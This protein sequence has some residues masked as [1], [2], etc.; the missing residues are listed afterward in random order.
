[1]DKPVLRISKLQRIGSSVGVTLPAVFV[2]RLGVSRGDY[3]R[4]ILDGDTISI[5][6]NDGTS[7]QHRKDTSRRGVANF[8]G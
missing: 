3:L 2:R 1:M 8:T 6:S 5:R 7:L 4:M